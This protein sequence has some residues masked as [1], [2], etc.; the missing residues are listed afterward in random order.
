MSQNTRIALQD[1]HIG[2][3]FRKD[4]GALDDLV[5]SFERVGQLNPILVDQDGTLIAGARRVE[6][7]RILGWP[8]LEARVLSLDNPLDAQID[9]D[10]QRKPLTLSE[11]VAVALALEDRFAAAALDRKRVRSAKFSQVKAEEKGRADDQIARRLG[12]S[13]T[14]LNRAKAIV[15]SATSDPFRFEDLVERMDRS[16][17]VDGAYRQW[18]MRSFAIVSASSNESESNTDRGQVIVIHPSWA[19]LV[20]SGSQGEACVADAISS[21]DIAGTD[22]VWMWTESEHLPIA[23]EVIAALGLRVSNTIAWVNAPPRSKGPFFDS[24]L[25]GLM[26]VRSVPTSVEDKL[27]TIIEGNSNCRSCLPTSFYGLLRMIHGSAMVSDLFPCPRHGMRTITEREAEQA[28]L[29]LRTRRPAL[30]LT[31]VSHGIAEFVV[32]DVA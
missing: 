16:N 28:S 13:R 15:Q 22:T 3:R 21:I 11:K 20:F 32:P 17:K 10:S 27:P 6:A 4:F 7:A 12:L 24:L 23:R 2:E 29:L 31:A 18:K 25:F 8:E 9:E 26:G 1:L 30:P 19:S 14:T 5:E